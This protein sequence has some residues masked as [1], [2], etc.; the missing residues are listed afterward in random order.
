ML[1]KAKSAESPVNKGLHTDSA[2]L[3]KE[4]SKN[5][6]YLMG[7]KQAKPIQNQLRIFDHGRVQISVKI[8]LAGR[9]ATLGLKNKMRI[10]F[11][12]A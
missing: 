6:R 2:R 1:P 9:T 10:W 4:K 5:S 7:I 12:G 11:F 8:E 3:F